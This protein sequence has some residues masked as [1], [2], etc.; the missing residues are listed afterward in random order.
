[1]FTGII[2]AT[3]AVRACDN[4]KLSVERPR[5]F[6][7]VQVGSS[8][9]VSGVCLTVKASDAQSLTFDTVPETLA[10][11][12]LGAL[13]PGDR[14][15]LERALSA[16]GRFEGHIVQGHAEGA[17]EVTEIQPCE[18]ES[19]EL[20]IRLPQS[21]ARRAVS[22]GSI[23]VDGVSL[24]IA[25]VDG[26]DVRIALIPHTLESTTLGSLNVSDHVNIETDILGRYIEKLL[27]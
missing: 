6:D 10:K 19:R 17:G 2:E 11:T 22:K 4:G 13:N 20:V 1:M 18:D 23:A 15:N 5:I 25:E 8:I 9:C 3:A 21:L 12:T 24:T 16:S 27:P 26:C 14:V 7:D